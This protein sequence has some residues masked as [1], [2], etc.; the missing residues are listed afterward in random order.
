MAFRSLQG[1]LSGTLKLPPNLVEMLSLHHVLLGVPPH[2]LSAVVAVLVARH[3][4]E[5]PCFIEGGGQWFT[6]ALMHEKVSYLTG[7]NVV[8]KKH[9]GPRGERFEVTTSEGKKFARNIVFTANPSQW[10]ACSNISIGWWQRLKLSRN[11]NPYALVVGYFATKQP[12]Q[13]VGFFNANHW[14]MGTLSS[15]QSYQ[16]LPPTVLA[17]QAPIFLSTGS[18]RDPKAVESDNGLGAQGVF[19]AMFL[20]PPKAEL[21]NVGDSTK[22]KVPETRGGFARAYASEKEKVLKILQAR[23]EKE[24]PKLKGNICWSELGTPLTHERYLFSPSRNGYGF[25][26]TVANLLLWRPSYKTSTPGLYFCGAHIKPAHGIATAMLNGLGLAKIL[27]R[28]NS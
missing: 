18:L 22:Y 26:A 23:L 9:A 1:Y 16:Q 10:N 3:Y 4:F 28:A 11:T 21:W 17:M 13:D 27:E 25:A 24:F 20:M 2:Q 15:A 5:N 19:Q 8:V 14:L 7:E 12:L 6:S